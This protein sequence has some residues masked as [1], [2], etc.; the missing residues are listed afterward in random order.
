MLSKDVIR[1]QLYQGAETKNLDYKEAFDWNNCSLD[2]RLG[3][4]KDILGMSNTQDGGVI[5][6]GV[7]DDSYEVSGITAEQTES[8]DQT[9]LGDMIRR[10]SDP[11]CIAQLYKHEIDNKKLIAIEIPE[12]KDIPHLCKLDGNSST[13]KKTLLRRGALYIRTDR[14]TT[15]EV[16][17]AEEMRGLLGRALKARGDSIVSSIRALLSGS[18][19]AENTSNG[20]RRQIDESN[21]FFN[22]FAFAQE[23]GKWML[24]SLPAIFEQERLGDSREITKRID[25]SRVSLRGWSFPHR[26]PD[27]VSNFNEGVQSNYTGRPLVVMHKEA[28]RAYASGLFCWQGIFWEDGQPLQ[29]GIK[30]LTFIGII[31]EPVEF[32]LFLSRYYSFLQDDEGVLVRVEATGLRNRE[33]TARDPNIVWDG[34]YRAG[35]DSFAFQRTIL[36]VELKT[37][38]MDFALE[39]SRKLL[40]LFNWNSVTDDI[41]RAWQQRLLKRSY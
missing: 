20:F 41:I 12:F 4:V 24:T 38:P 40:L 2:T 30:D 11:P 15:E 36:A 14:A 7:K 31:W 22:S 13:S 18:P 28:Y 3:L 32:F 26:Q 37:A 21:E 34:G 16:G 9:R 33:L 23:Q 29:S 17:S 5:L 10:Y 6:I 19:P 27:N 39:C 1:Q 35:V 8:F 25:H